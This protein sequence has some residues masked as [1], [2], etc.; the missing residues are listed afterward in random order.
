MNK[1][2]PADEFAKLSAE[3][4]ERIIDAQAK[5]AI[6]NGSAKE[7]MKAEWI[8]QHGP[9]VCNPDD[10]II[11]E[12]C[13][14]RA[15]R[16]V[17]KRAFMHLPLEERRKILVEQIEKLIDYYNSPEFD[18]LGGGDFI[19]YLSDEDVLREKEA[20]D[21]FKHGRFDTVNT[22]EELKALFDAKTNK[23]DDN[24]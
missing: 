1:R 2:I 17:E 13:I 12:E 14:R 5:Q 4:Q 22:D 24:E 18:G 8:E 3:E 20:D 23:K 9:F 19:D 15:K 16:F 21:D 7:Q 11:T 6:E 10:M